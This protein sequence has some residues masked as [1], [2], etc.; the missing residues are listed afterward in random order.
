VDAVKDICLPISWQMMPKTIGVCR[1][2]A[3][4]DGQLETNM[5]IQASLASRIAS[6]GTA[7]P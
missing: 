2:I 5:G 7:R 1:C 3:G 4:G 6:G